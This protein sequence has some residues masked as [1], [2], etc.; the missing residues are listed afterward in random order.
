ML[1]S[2]TILVRL[3]SHIKYQIRKKIKE[4]QETLLGVAKGAFSTHREEER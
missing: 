2:R 4:Q 3:K 1:Q